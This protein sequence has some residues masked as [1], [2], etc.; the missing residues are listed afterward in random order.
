MVRDVRF[1][2][3]LEDTGGRLQTYRLLS[4]EPYREISLALRCSVPP[5]TLAKSL[6]EA[7][8]ELDPELPVNAILPAVRVVENN[9]VN[10]AFTGS[11]LKDFALLGLL[12]AAVGIYGV[13]SS[14][15]AQRT[16]EI[17]IRMAL[18]AQVRD[19]LALVLSQG[20][21]LSMLGI[22][23]G[24]LGAWWVA[25]LLKSTV[26]GLPNSGPLIV[27]GIALLLFAVALLACWLPARRAAK[28]DPME[29]LR[30]E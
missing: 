26:P 30:S 13:I 14:F 12:L 3:N 6:R 16:S 23:I 29:A 28:V 4:R 24:L 21:R 20:V 15:V 10:Y 7:V 5:E 17:G 11:L 18:G 8:A 1:A 2:S 25:R 19:V 9:T 22:G 27:I